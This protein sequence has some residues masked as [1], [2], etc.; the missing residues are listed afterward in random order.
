[1]GRAGSVSD[2]RPSPAKR[3][4]PPVADARGSPRS[5]GAPVPNIYLPPASG[6]QYSR[7]V[8]V[9]NRCGH[10]LEP[11]RSQLQGPVLALNRPR[12][13]RPAGLMPGLAMALQPIEG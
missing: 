1:M 11:L 3:F 7:G 9:G 6:A 13:F 5:K 8:F 12:L 4:V 2:R 10:S